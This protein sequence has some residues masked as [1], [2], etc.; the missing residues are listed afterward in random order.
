M[1]AQIL[2]EDLCTRS[3]DQMLSPKTAVITRKELRAIV[4]AGLLPY[5]PDTTP[6]RAGELMQEG[7]T[8]GTSTVEETMLFV[9]KALAVAN[10]IPLAE[11]EKVLAEERA[12]AEVKAAEEEKVVVPVVKSAGRGT[13][14]K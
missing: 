9:S 11:F 5:Y 14:P 1:N 2:V 7:I 10:G 3:I 4:Y 8:T 12:K 6:N 13:K